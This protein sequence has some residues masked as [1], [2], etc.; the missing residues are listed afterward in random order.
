MV[1]GWLMA[2]MTAGSVV[3]WGTTS[4]KYPF[5]VTGNATFYKYSASYTSGLIHHV[6][7]KGLQPA[8]RSID[9]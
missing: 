6:T 1:V 4:G 3:S 7:L 9:F 5:I 2:N 8:K